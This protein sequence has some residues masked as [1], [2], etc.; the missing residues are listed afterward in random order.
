M[1]S[2]RVIIIIVLLLLVFG[3]FSGWQYAHRR[4]YR[5]LQA[6]ERV[7]GAHPDSALSLLRKISS[8]DRLHGRNRAYYALLLTQAYYKNYLPVTDDSLIR[9]AADY[10]ASGSD[11][12]RK[13]QSYFYLAQVY[14]DLGDRRRSL[15]CFHRADLSAEGCR[16]YK[17]LSLLYYHWGCLLQEEKP[18]S[19][20]LSKLYRANFY[21]KLL[22]DT[23]R[24]VYSLMEMGWSYI[25]LEKYDSAYYCLS[26][27]L[28]LENRYDRNLYKLSA[29]HHRLAIC[30]YLNGKYREA[31]Y[32][33]NKETWEEGSAPRRRADLMKGRSFAGLQQLDS[34]RYY[35]ERIRQEDDLDA[36]LEYNLMSSRLCRQ[37]GDFRQALAY[38]EQYSLYVDSLTHRRENERV[39]QWQKK[40]DYSL[41]R[42]ENMR[43]KTESQQKDIVTLVCIIILL[44]LVPFL[45]AVYLRFKRRKESFLR[46]Q[47]QL[48]EA[49]IQSL[50]AKDSEL[51]RIRQ[52]LASKERKWRE[53]VFLSDPLVK[54]IDTFVQLSL[55]DK[56]R[57]SS[58]YKLSGADLDHLI[59][60]LNS[61]HNNYV[62]RLQ[63]EFPGLKE[64][65]MSICCLLR[66]HIKNRDIC[67]LLGISDDA[68]KKRKYRIKTDKLHLRDAEISLEDFLCSY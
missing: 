2:S 33:L 6:V 51:L 68:L 12:L 5:E 35:I 64:I 14:R 24:W 23:A 47:H 10:Y 53:S 63:S 40:Y 66:M 15:D 26:K 45:Y 34:A 17:Y 16:D 9:I 31:L 7:M 8:P 41:V 37:E 67:Y 32:H 58:S 49:N 61:C 36:M 18:Y 21:E 11:S 29:L 39:M 50:Q 38:H 4:I 65:E 43:L 44:L 3:G 62:S 54:H 1:K 19:E 13:S 20:G 59:S 28:E 55:L 52:E 25:L 56:D 57:L 27:G 42:N 46:R 22:G 30:Y 60:L 48:M